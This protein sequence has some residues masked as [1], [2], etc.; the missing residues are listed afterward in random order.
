MSRI[1]ILSLSDGR[2]FVSRDTADFIR[3][4]E[5]D[6]K[7]CLDEAGHDVVVAD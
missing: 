6:L 4:I 5:A 1:A 3:A 2:D 7:G